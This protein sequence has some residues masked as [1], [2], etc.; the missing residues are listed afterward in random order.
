M[1][2]LK[3]FVSAQF[4]Q[5]HWKILPAE[6]LDF[7]HSGLPAYRQTGLNVEASEL[8][9]AKTLSD[10][11]KELALR[12]AR[13][14]EARKCRSFIT[15]ANIPSSFAPRDFRSTIIPKVPS[16][17]PPATTGTLSGIHTEAKRVF[18][19]LRKRKDNQTLTDLNTFLFNAKK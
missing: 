10:I 9:P 14:S 15:L 19:K 3:N 12:A 13:D 6:L 16:T 2:E 1:D 4:L 18:E 5:S 11:T 8:L 7:I 17:P